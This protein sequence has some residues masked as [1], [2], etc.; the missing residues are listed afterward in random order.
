VEIKLA[1]LG[2]LLG[3]ACGVAGAQPPPPA[4]PAVEEAKNHFKS[5]TELYDENNFRGALV[6]FQ[7]AYELSPSYR[8]L[9]NIGQVDM[10]LQDYA[11]ALKA[12]SRYLREGGPD[13][14]APRRAQVQSEV[15][16]L[17]GRVGQITIQ[18]VPGAEILIDD[19]SIGFAPLPEAATVN[20]G[21]HQVVVHVSGHD[22]LSRVVDVAGQQQLS[23]VLGNELAVRSV[24]A[25]PEPRK[26]PSK[27]P[28][29]VAWVAGGAFAVTAGI[30][31]IVAHSDASDLASLRQS[32]PVTKAQLDSQLSKET[33]AAHVADGFAL[34]ALVAGGLGLYLT[35]TH[36]S[37]AE[38]DKVV[39]LH[40]GPAGAFVT[41]RF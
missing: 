37:D 8:I 29:R 31:A 9:F 35:L 2:V 30:F 6:E 21:R 28:M 26:P 17:K 15:D 41:G 34:A 13:V 12:Y 39:Q 18:T 14:P 22:P 1:H 23:V 27:L 3:L 19:I 32:F 24:A 25:A 16:R 36:P 4:T 11:G 40:V 10:E 7:R 38:A 33:T 5:G 20:T